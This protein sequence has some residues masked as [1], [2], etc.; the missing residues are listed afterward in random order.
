MTAFNEK[1]AKPQR[2]RRNR[3]GAFRRLAASVTKNAPRY[4]T[5]WACRMAGLRLKRAYERAGAY[6]S[7]RHLYDEAIW[8][9]RLR[10]L[11]L[12]GEDLDGRFSGCESQAQ[13]TA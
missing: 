3:P 8:A 6:G 7:E 10:W 1:P 12:F 11:E 4:R 2:P 13:E 9:C 5:A